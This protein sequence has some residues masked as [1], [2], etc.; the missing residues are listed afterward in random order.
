[1]FLAGD[2]GGTKSNLGAFEVREGKLRCLHRQKYPSQ[3][4]ARFEDVLEAFCRE[5]KGKFR[6]ACFGV[7]G[8]VFQNRVHATNLP[9][10]LDGRELAR[11]LGV[12]RVT[13]L[14]DMDASFHGTAVL[15]PEEIYPLQAG[16][17]ARHTNQ[18]LIAAGTGLGEAIR[19]WTGRRYVVV[20]TEGGHADFAPRTEQEIELLRFMKKVHDPVS[21]ELLVSGRGFQA[22]HEF[23]DPSV[24]H[25]GFDDPHADPAPDITHQ[26]LE[27][28]CT[29]CVETVELWVEL[30]GAEAGNL[31]LKALARGG[32]Y[33]AGGI[34]VK[35]FP[36]MK[37]G[38]FVEAFVRKE[39]FE[40]V[41]AEFPIWLVLNQDAPLLGAAAVAAG[42]SR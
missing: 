7:A 16:S 21:V 19:F 6:A 14:N 39:K 38:R 5:F 27:G 40:K 18:A 11:H 28:T 26:A 4:F 25:P 20:A 13:L 3:E 17:P 12:E 8:P 2:L 29:A 31:A 10:L 22:I 34:A 30:Y 42:L 36:K 33:V 15:A 41:L 37:D 1:M 9:W 23:L 35:I 24:R 32:V